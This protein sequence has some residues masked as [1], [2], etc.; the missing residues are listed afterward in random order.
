MID[1][2]SVETVIF[3]IRSIIDSK[4]LKH[5]VIAEKA[6]YSIQQFSNLLNQ[7]KNIECSDI[8]RIATALDVTPNELFGIKPGE[9]E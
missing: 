9:E 7:R 4:G 8:W 5:K 1:L 6:G 2:N 3:N